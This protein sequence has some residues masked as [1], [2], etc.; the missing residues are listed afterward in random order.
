M[1]TDSGQTHGEKKKQGPGRGHLS[2]SPV[3]RSPDLQAR[4]TSFSKSVYKTEMGRVRVGRQ[5]WAAAP[6]P[7]CQQAG[8]EGCPGAAATP[9]ECMCKLWRAKGVHRLQGARGLMR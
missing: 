9:L 8:K 3:R 6:A 4:S 2:L 7:R 5:G 1:R